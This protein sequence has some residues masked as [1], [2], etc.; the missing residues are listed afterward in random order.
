[1]RSSDI[2]LRHLSEAA[3]YLVDES[4][5]IVQHVLELP[6]EAGSPN[7]FHFYAHAGNTRAFCNQQNSAEAGGAARDREIAAAKALGEAVERYCSAIYDL[8][9]LPLFSYESRPFTCVSPDEFAL[10]TQN[11][12]SCDR[13]PYVPLKHPMPVHWT[14]ALDLMTGDICHVPA[15]MIFVPYFFDKARG[16]RP[17]MQPISTGLACHVGSTRAAVSAIC[18]VVE[19]DAFTITWQARLARSV[20]TNKTLSDENRE[21][22]ERFERI[23]AQVTLLNLTMD[24]GIPVILSVLKNR[25]TDAP[26]LVFAVSSS[27]DPEQAVKKSLEELAHGYRFCRLLKN[28][29]P[30]FVPTPG[31]SN[32]VN[33]EGHVGLYCDHANV[34]L[35]DFIFSSGRS[36]DFGEIENLSTGSVKRD[37]SV[38]VDRVKMINHRI[39]LA[40][41]TTDDVRSLG[42]S[43]MR[44]V[45]PGFHPL[46]IGHHVRALGGHRLWQVPQMLGYEGISKETGDN[47][48]PHPVP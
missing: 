13:F 45:I 41:V 31:F 11:Q 28:A 30:S 29:K 16:E 48:L 10:Y 39:L 38:L 22:V 19:R 36:I 32:V 47:P 12:Y 44:A 20:I 26:A 4:V 43:V 42:L 40:D 25:A 34:G 7:F 27:L 5:G 15:A 2:S 33:R 37:L 18:E 24:H 8:A 46:C 35:A 3:D 21:L 14:P 9:D 23:G 17:F 6:L 1:M